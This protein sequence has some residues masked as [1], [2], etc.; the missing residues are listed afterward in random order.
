MTSDELIRDKFEILALDHGFTKLDLSDRN[1]GGYSNS[2]LQMNWIFWRES[3]LRLVK[4]LEPSWN[5]TLVSLPDL[6][7]DVFIIHRGKLGIAHLDE[8]VPS[9]DETFQRFEYWADDGYTEYDWPDVTHWREI[10]IELPKDI[11]EY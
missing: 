7:R 5:S 3:Y 1:L 4:P 9:W 8:E 11:S 2:Y 10:D 6:Y